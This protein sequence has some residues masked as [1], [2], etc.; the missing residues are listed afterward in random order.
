M[1]AIALLGTI[2]VYVFSY[3]YMIIWST[4][5]FTLVYFYMINLSACFFTIGNLYA[6]ILT[7]SYFAAG[8]I[9][10]QKQWGLY[11]W[12]IAMHMLMTIFYF[13]L[14]CI[15]F[16]NWGLPTQIPGV[17]YCI[18]KAFITNDV[19]LTTI[20]DNL[21]S[22]CHM[23]TNTIFILLLTATINR[24]C[25]ALGNEARHTCYGLTTDIFKPFFHRILNNS[26][27]KSHLLADEVISKP[28]FYS[29][30][31]KQVRNIMHTCV[32]HS[33]NL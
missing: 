9:F 27:S 16:I 13:S 30:D 3:F 29:N 5:Y 24:Y 18:M 33:L 21:L 23:L 2:E 6:I 22:S 15:F 7:T 1:H 10:T 19:L 8:D 26:L 20:I 17:I 14:K 12:S 28:T 25:F 4:S 11:D 32:S 31:K